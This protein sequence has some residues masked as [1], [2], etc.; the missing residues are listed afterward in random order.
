MVKEYE[1][2]VYANTLFLYTEFNFLF[3]DEITCNSW[4]FYIWNMWIFYIK[5]NFFIFL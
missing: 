4:K 3:I 5:S 1:T 2:C